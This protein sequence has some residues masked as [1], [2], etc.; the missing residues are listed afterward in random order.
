[1]PNAGFCFGCCNPP[2]FLKV[3]ALQEEAPDLYTYLYIV[4]ICMQML[5]IESNSHMDEQI[6]V[7]KHTRERLEWSPI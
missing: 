1:M 6:V 4:W 5:K 3:S 2:T 7:Y